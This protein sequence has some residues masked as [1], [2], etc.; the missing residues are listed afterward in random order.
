VG[1]AVV[2]DQRDAAVLGDPTGDPHGD[3]IPRLDGTMADIVE[4]PLITLAAAKFTELIPPP[5]NRSSVVPLAL[6][7]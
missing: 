1:V 3:P 5:Q 4:M 7:L 2:D 6:T